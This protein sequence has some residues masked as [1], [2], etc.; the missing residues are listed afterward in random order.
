[1]ATSSADGLPTPVAITEA[2]WRLLLTAV[3]GPLRQLYGEG[4]KTIPA[5]TAQNVLVADNSGRDQPMFVTVQVGAPS[6][7][8]F[9]RQPNAT[10]ANGF[11]HAFPTDGSTFSQILMPN[12]R[13]YANPLGAPSFFVIYG[14]IV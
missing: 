1:M 9:S 2:E 8:V 7:V 6:L 4:P 5:T 12:E 10:I 3:A 11:Q 14:S 13:L